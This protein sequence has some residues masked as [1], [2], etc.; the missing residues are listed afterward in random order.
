MLERL[1]LPA[2]C[3]RPIAFGLGL[4]ERLTWVLAHVFSFRGLC[5]I[6]LALMAWLTIG[7]WLRPPLSDDIRAFQLPLLANRS[8]DPSPAAQL[9]GPRPFVAVSPGVLLLAMIVVGVLIAL[10]RRDRFAVA[11]GLLVCG[12]LGSLASVLFNHPELVSLLDD[13]MEQRKQLIAVLAATTEPPLRVT[14]VARVEDSA[15]PLFEQ[16][17]LLRGGVYLHTHRLLLVL[18]PALACLLTTRGTLARRLGHLGG[19][20]AAGLL[21]AGIVAFPRLS[22]EWQWGLATQADWRGD[23]DAAERHAAAAIAHL[24]EFTRLERT[25]VLL[26]QLDYR[27]GRAS[28][29]GR[30]FHAYQWAHNKQWRQAIEEM[31]DLACVD[32]PVPL[33]HRWL[34][35][36][37]ARFAF[38]EFHDDRWQAAEDEWQRAYELDST[39]SFRP[40]L[41]ATVRARAHRG[42]PEA[43][44]ALVDPLLDQ[45][46][47]DRTMRAALL[48]MLGDAYFKADRFVE[49][50]ARYEESMAAYNLPKHVNFR[51]QRG[52]LGM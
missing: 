5:L 7:G 1:A 47:S 9:Y 4:L 38:S 48:A 20:S 17:S 41:V 8:Y 14:D 33:I 46:R 30:Y 2:W 35:N 28:W 10:R 43:I 50:R 27:R 19:W 23:T 37:R 31:E 11:A 42:D 6:F 51:A 36:L 16:G 34:A 22:A 3:R 25:W 21:F 44:A 26:G 24:P 49:A 15:D 32:E 12:V 13:Q 39:P 18:L 52:L 29:A 45:L 40:L